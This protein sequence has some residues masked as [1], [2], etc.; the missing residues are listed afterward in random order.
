MFLLTQSA[1]LFLKL[2]CL[3]KCLSIVKFVVW[4]KC[5]FM[6]NII[7]IYIYFSSCPARTFAMVRKIPVQCALFSKPKGF[8]MKSLTTCSCQTVKMTEWSE[9]SRFV[10]VIQSV[11]RLH[12]ILH[13][14]TEMWATLH[15]S[16][17]C[18][19][20]QRSFKNFC[21]LGHLVNFET[22]HIRFVMFWTY[23]W[24]RS[25]LSSEPLFRCHL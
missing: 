2:S 18:I 15:F 12:S 9:F 19:H 16:P 23:V 21:L 20:H 5:G 11:T 24:K 1:H 22:L 8:R 14:S 25:A 7:V 3:V 13:S 17:F 4:K 6:A 10:R